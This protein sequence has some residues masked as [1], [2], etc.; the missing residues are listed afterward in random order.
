[1]ASKFGDQV[2]AFA[3]KA[4]LRQ[5][6]IFRQSA[7]ALMDEAGTPEG[8][9]GKMPVD[10]GTLRNSAVAS[11]EGM[12][13]S[14]SPAYSLVFSKLVVGETVYAGWTVAYSLRM[15]HG[16]VGKD[17]L[18]RQYNQAGKGFMRSAAQNWDFIVAATTEQVKKDIP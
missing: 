10:T 12:P 9:G 14:S 2:K 15:E 6:A 1:M 11:K 3:D 7:Q 17:S 4:K 5:E 18:G 16:F 13:D 8:R